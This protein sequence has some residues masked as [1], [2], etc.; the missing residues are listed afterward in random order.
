MEDWED[1]VI[2]HANFGSLANRALAQLLGHILSEQT[3]ASVA[4]QHDPYRIFVQTMS[5]ANADRLIALFSDLKQTPQATVKDMLTTATVKTGLFKRRMIHVA[6]RF[7]ALKKWA[8]FS[9]VSL[10]SLVKSFESSIINEEALKEVFTKDLDLQRLLQILHDIQADK[11][12]VIKIDN[13]G[14]ASPVARLGVERVSMK[15]DLIP[16]ERMKAILIESAKA[17]LLNEVRTFICT[18]NWD[19]TEMIRLNDLPDRPACPKCG[20]IRL[21]LLS[22]EEE[23]ILSFVDKKG[24]KMTKSEQ[25]MLEKALETAELMS[26]YGK[27]AAVALAGRRVR[28]QDA[29]NVLRKQ[30]ALSDS[31][32]E[33]VI[34]AERDALKRRFA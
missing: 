22:R 3:G 19:Y 17:R 21:G 5:I 13:K 12:E 31:F 9:T 32:F 24:E 7:G 4:V 18:Q 2:I 10:S 30:H 29:L 33:L 28:T 14:T 8:D 11:I 15:T 26:D 16:S 27:A 6:R 34:E 1:F 23:R 20:S 25:K